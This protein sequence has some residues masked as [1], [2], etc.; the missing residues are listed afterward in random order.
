MPEVRPFVGLLFDPAVAGPLD[1]LTA[2]PYDLISVEDQSRLYRASPYNIVRLV[3]GKDEPGDN[4]SEDKYTRAASYLSSWRSKGVL[5]PTPEPCMYP[6]ELRFQLEGR[7]RRIRGVIAEVSLD[8]STRTIVPHERTMPGPVRDRLRLLRNVQ[9]NLSPIYTVFA[10]PAPKL[11]Q[12]LKTVMNEP[13][14]GEVTDE[15]GTTHTLWA[16]AEHADA[17]AG[18]VKDKILMIADGHHRYRVALAYQDEM[19]D[20]RGPGPWDSMMMLIVDAGSEDPPVLPI[21]RVVRTE[22]EQASTSGRKVRDLAEVLASV[23]DE[24]LT[25]GSVSWEDG[26]VVHRVASLDGDPPTVR[27]L[28]DH[29]LD[30]LPDVELRFTADVVA[31]ERAV[32]DQDASVAYF[33]PPTKV[34]RVWSLVRAGEKM[35]QKSTYFWPKPR[36]GLVIRPFLQD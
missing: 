29:V 35:P 4:P 22:A 9:A 17:I 30:A 21:H 13:P 15:S 10:E 20:G 18:T 14:R 1:N 3:L 24:D 6:Y 26:N 34:E 23:R 5:V 28:H 36:T 16:T 33:L 27:A 2:P 31:A 32:L 8:S 25:Y 12:V 7:E 19:R 11:S